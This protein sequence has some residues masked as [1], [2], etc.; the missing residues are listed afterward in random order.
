M[1]AGAGRNPPAHM[2]G[3]SYIIGKQISP[4]RWH[5]RAEEAD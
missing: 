2:N 3:Y 4:A 1:T 5:L